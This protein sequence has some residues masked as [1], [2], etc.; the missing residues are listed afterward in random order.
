VSGRGRWAAYR[1]PTLLALVIWALAT[2]VC[3][4][5]GLP[6]FLAWLVGGSVATLVLYGL[7]KRQAQRGGR[8]TPERLLFVLALA[9]GVVGAWAGMFLFRHKTRH[10]S[11]YIV[12]GVATVLYLA[13]AVW[14]LAR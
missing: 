12:N 6:P 9:G 14:L 4:A 10:A 7:D 2:V 11:F 1:T 3:F 8:R 5:V 13:L